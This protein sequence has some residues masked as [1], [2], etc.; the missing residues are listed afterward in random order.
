MTKLEAVNQML[1][2]AG[3]GIVGSVPSQGGSW[4]VQA[5]RLL[6]EVELEIQSIGWNYNTLIDV[7]LTPNADDEIVVP[8]S[9]ITIDTYGR[10]K[11]VNTRFIG[12]K[13]YDITNNT[14]E[15]TNSVRVTYTLRYEFECIPY[16]VQSYIAAKAA[17]V[18]VEQNFGREREKIRS[19]YE[20]EDMA[21]ANAKNYNNFE[22]NRNVINTPEAMIRLGDRN[23]WGFLT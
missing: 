20:R 12:G 2:Q 21:N 15:F 9:V 1:A 19:A 23:R 5:N 13:L 18:F 11:Q 7:E 14:T 10:D 17:R 3:L 8:D 6:D 22:S 4:A 16:P